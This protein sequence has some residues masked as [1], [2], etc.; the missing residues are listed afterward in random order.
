ML[1]GQGKITTI[2][3]IDY[4]NVSRYGLKGISQVIFTSRLVIFYYIEDSTIR[5]LKQL[6]SR[7]PDLRIEFF[8]HEKAAANYA[9]FQIDTYLGF[10]IGRESGISNFCIISKDRGFDA[11]I[12]FWT[13]YGVNVTKQ[14]TIS[15]APLS[16]TITEA[17]TRADIQKKNKQTDHAMPAPYRRKVAV[18][19]MN[20]GLS[21]V[22][23]R[24]VRE[25]MALCRTEKRLKN[26]IANNISK[27]NAD[28]IYCRIIGIYRAWKKEEQDAA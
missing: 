17:N 1:K 13:K 19:L 16:D 7:Y 15:G 25:Y 4:E 11:V 27:V 3:I 6:V 9:D 5:H 18:A 2:Y 26:A 8:M 28:D 20:T 21:S 14:Q 22:Q 10:L 23:V 24:K 12:D